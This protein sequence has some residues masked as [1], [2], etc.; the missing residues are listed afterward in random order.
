MC[1]VC[2]LIGSGAELARGDRQERQGSYQA[3]VLPVKWQLASSPDGTLIYSTHSVDNKLPLECITSSM[4]RETDALQGYHYCCCYCGVLLLYMQPLAEP[5][6]RLP[7]TLSYHTHIVLPANLCSSENDLDRFQI[8]S[9]P[10]Y[11]GGA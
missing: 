7:G 8:E 1:F 6:A 3:T 5:S 11:F 2:D 9:V 4:P 10:S